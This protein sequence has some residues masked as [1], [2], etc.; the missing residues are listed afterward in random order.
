MYPFISIVCPTKDRP[1]CVRVLL[2]SLRQ[3]TANDFE[4]IISD[5]ADLKPCKGA[6]DEYRSNSK[7]NIQYHRTKKCLGICDS[8]EFAISHANGK[9]VMVVEDKTILYPSAIEKISGCLQRDNLDI[10]N[11]PWDFLNPYDKSRNIVRGVLTRGYRC[12]KLLGIDPEHALQ[13]KFECQKMTLE[14]DK[15][16]NYGAIMGGVCSANFLKIM[17]EMNGGRLFDGMVPDR[18]FAVEALCIVSPG[19]IKFLDDH[20]LIYNSN[21]R[22]TTNYRSLNNSVAVFQRSREE[23]RYYDDMIFPGIAIGHN[24]LASDF[25]RALGFVIS[26]GKY[27]RKRVPCIPRGRLLAILEKKIASYTADYEEY[28]KEKQLI[29]TYKARMSREEEAQYKEK[30]AEMKKGQL[31]SSVWTK[32]CEFPNKEFGFADDFAACGNLK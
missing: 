18:Y 6:V 20:I 13:E 24:V 28:E 21:G 22:N 32:R 9:Y 11:F 10:L 5:N 17:K 14:L 25:E 31:L 7:L 2:E 3:Q 30:V 26:A 12:G 15:E 23:K 16:W 27:R 19:K 8:F 4:I 29:E 1:E